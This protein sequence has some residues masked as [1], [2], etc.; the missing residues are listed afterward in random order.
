MLTVTKVIGHASDATLAERLHALG[1]A[2][3]IETLTIDRDDTLRRRL[4]GTTDRGTEVA[5]AL[6]RS[7]RLSDGA[8]LVLEENHAIVVRM[9]EEMWLKVTPRDADSALE[10]GYF[11]GNLHWRVRFEP[12]A[13]LIALEGPES[14]YTGR[15][16][17]LTMQGK[18]RITPHG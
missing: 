4:R 12:G 3:R 17:H 9:S 11:I 8:V 7:E 14:H 6:N 1:H 2:D 5:I 18:I 16:A 10:A 15:L 13:I